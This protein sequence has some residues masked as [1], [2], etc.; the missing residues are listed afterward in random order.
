MKKA[1][2]WVV[3]ALA[4]LLVIGAIVGDG[5]NAGKKFTGKFRV[6]SG[7]EYVT[8]DAPSS[9]GGACDGW[10]ALS[11]QKNGDSG[12][13]LTNILCW[14]RIGDEIVLTDRSGAQKTSGPA[15]LWSD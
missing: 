13:G 15:K 14:T 3:G 5:G 1:L 7:T 10:S 12:T 9:I 8:L 11:I 6:D 4:I 2:L